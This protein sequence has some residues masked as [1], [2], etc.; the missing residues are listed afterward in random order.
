[1]NGQRQQLS[2]AKINTNK[3]N[4]LS[5]KNFNFNIYT[6]FTSC[7]CRFP[8]LVDRAKLSI[9]NVEVPLTRVVGSPLGV[10][11]PL[12]Q[13]VETVDDENSLNA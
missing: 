13:G 4:N 12:A 7:I 11:P 1:M 2:K 10:V 3:Q 9:N 8:H 5:H 6:P